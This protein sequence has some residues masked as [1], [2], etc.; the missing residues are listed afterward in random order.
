[1]IVLCCC[2]FFEENSKLRYQRITFES[3]VNNTTFKYLFPVREESGGNMI[4]LELIQ[5]DKV[6]TTVLVITGILWAYVLFRSFRM[7]MHQTNQFQ[8]EYEHILNED[9]Y[10]VKGRFEE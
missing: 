2:Y 8:V 5:Q 7:R 1:M 4:L 6:L 10:K 9:K 3:T